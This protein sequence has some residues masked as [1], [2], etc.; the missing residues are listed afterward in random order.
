MRLYTSPAEQKAAAAA[1]QRVK[2]KAPALLFEERFSGG[3]FEIIVTCPPGFRFYGMDAHEKVTANAGPIA[4]S[5]WQGVEADVLEIEP[6]TDADCEW[7]HEE[8][9]AQ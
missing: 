7:C 8:A 3:W 6:C 5:L 2:R 4:D 1:R 9:E